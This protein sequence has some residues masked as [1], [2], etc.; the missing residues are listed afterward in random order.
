[1]NKT[2]T[3]SEARNGF[4]AM[5]KLIETP[6][7]SVTITYEGHPKGVLMSIED[8][9][10][11]METLDIMAHSEEAKEII[12]RLHNWRNEKTVTLEEFK[13]NLDLA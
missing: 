13:K 9:E 1:M 4:F 6:G 8:F 11:W 2:V 10:G 7:V 12:E 5:L 3:A